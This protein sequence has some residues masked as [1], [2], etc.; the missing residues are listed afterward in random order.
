MTVDHNGF[1]LDALPAEVREAAEAF[2]ADNA[3]RVAELEELTARQSVRISEQDAH[4]AGQTQRISDQVQQ[5][6]DQ[7]RQISGQVQ[8]ISD[9]SRKI[10]DLDRQI[11]RKNALILRQESLISELKRALYGKK[12]EKLSKDE[13]NLGA[14][15]IEVALSETEASS[16][17]ATQSCDTEKKAKPPRKAPERNIGNLPEDLPRVEQVIEPDSVE[18]PCGC[19][20]MHKI[21]EDRS[22]RLDIVP[23]QLRVIVTVRPKYACRTCAG[24]VKQAP[25]PFWLIE[26]GLPTE[27]AIA[28]VLVSKYADHLPLYRQSQILARSGIDIHRATLAGWVG[29]AA[30]HLKP[31]VERLAEHLKSSTKLF[32]PSRQHALHAPAG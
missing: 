12:S 10:T 28:H 26:G 30:F 31:I 25:G 5:I 20:A 15:D 7:D 14:E 19:G 17:A 18:C 6:S 32:M 24:G 9:Q 11:A 1:N 29:K 13:R 21:G 27:A 23:A 8:Q 22:E 2:L 16:E 4:I 3:R